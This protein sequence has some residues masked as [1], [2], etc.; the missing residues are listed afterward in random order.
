VVVFALV[1]M[2]PAK[3]LTPVQAQ[4]LRVFKRR[5]AAGLPPPTYRELCQEFGWRSTG[6]ARDH[7]RALA[8]KGLVQPG[9]GKARG[10]C[11]PA[12]RRGTLALPLVGR[13]AAGRPVL[14]EQNVEDEVEVPAFLAPR[15]GGFLLRVAG[16]SMEGAAILD[17]DLVVIAPAGRPRAGSIV[18]VTVG[19]ETT[20]KRLQ[21]SG[22]RWWLVAENPRYAPIEIE[23]EDC[24]LHGEVTGVLRRVGPERTHR[25]TGGRP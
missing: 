24:V 10:T 25:T 12:G 7:I 23:G 11:L 18:A 5:A 19:G 20:L 15:Q 2:T 4:V 6:T 16:D 3:A 1:L 9:L 14:S 17:G 8:R 13:I 21:A 22:T